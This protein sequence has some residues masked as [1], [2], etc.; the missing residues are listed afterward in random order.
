MIA[1]AAKPLKNHFRPPS[2]ASASILA[3][4]SLAGRRRSVRNR[5]APNQKW[6]MIFVC[7]GGTGRLQVAW[8]IAAPDL[9]VSDSEDDRYLLADV[10]L[11]YSANEGPMRVEGA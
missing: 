9:Q 8:E 3:V 4:D 6:K 5:T 11:Q 10:A 7:T 1:G 2:T